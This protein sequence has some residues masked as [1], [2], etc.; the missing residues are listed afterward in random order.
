[1]CIRDRLEGDAGEILA[2]LSGSF[3]FI[4]MDAAKGQYIRW[5]P[6]LLRLLAPGGLLLSDN[7]DVYKRQASFPIPEAGS[8]A[9][10][11]RMGKR[12]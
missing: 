9:A 8:A 5:L 1:M 11:W 6:D 2:G 4:F 12:K 3:D 10:A 7:V